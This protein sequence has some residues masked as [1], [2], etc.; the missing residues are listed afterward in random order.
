MKNETT[1]SPVPA[2]ARRKAA[3]W[4]LDEAWGN[5]QGQCGADPWCPGGLKEKQ[6]LPDEALNRQRESDDKE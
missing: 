3:A 1:P 4:T 6:R 2:A 5:C